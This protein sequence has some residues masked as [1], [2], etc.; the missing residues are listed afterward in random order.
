LIKNRRNI[1]IIG[2]LIIVINLLNSSALATSKPDITVTPTEPTP[3]SKI[4]FT[5]QITYENVTDVK[6]YVQECST[7]LCYPEWLNKTME[8][9]S[10]GKYQGDITLKH[11]NA[12]YIYY[13]LVVTANGSIY[14]LQNDKVT[15]N[16]KINTSNG[17]DDNKSPGFELI[18]LIIGITL[19]AYILKKKRFE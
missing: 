14:D 6:I 3:L 12:A 17:N 15:L 5:A 8:P 2:V 7:T 9:L 16:L 1:I 4:T 19:L 11:S 18:I 10:S 13:W